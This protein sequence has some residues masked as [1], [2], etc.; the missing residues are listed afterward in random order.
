MSELLS[1]AMERTARRPLRAEER[2]VIVAR[3]ASELA[4]ISAEPPRLADAVC[5]RALE[6]PAALREHIDAFWK[7]PRL[8]SKSLT[9]VMRRAL[10]PDRRVVVQF[11]P[12]GG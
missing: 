7:A 5:R 11:S 12:F 6:A 8:R 3:K 10:K 4:L 2:A 1:A 9:K